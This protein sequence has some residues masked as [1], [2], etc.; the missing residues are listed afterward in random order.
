LIYAHVRAQDVELRAAVDPARRTARLRLI[1]RISS[2][3]PDVERTHTFGEEGGTIGRADDNSWVLRHPKV[4]AHHAVI[5]FSGGQ[6]FVEDTS[7][8]G[9]LVNYVRAIGP[10]PSRSKPA[11]VL[12]GS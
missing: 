9:V 5:S 6:F 10:R 8:L 1:L 4:S 3:T 2:P 7:D 11:S 12:R